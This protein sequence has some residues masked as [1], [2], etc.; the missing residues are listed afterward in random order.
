MVVEG[1]LQILQKQ[2]YVHIHKSQE[3]YIQFKSRLKFVVLSRN[4]DSQ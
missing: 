1:A 3:L 2:F 4:L